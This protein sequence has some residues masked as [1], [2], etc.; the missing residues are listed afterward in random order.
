[1]TKTT[2]AAAQQLASAAGADVAALKQAN[3]AS[4][5]SQKDVLANAMANAALQSGKL[6]E[7]VSS[8]PA[9]AKNAPTAGMKTDIHKHFQSDIG[10]VNL[11]KS[12]ISAEEK[13]RLESELA[14][15]KGSETKVY[16]GVDNETVEITK[17]QIPSS[18]YVVYIK[19]SNNSVFNIK[20]S[21]TKVMVEGC[22]NVTVN[23]HNGTKVLTQVLEAWNC[24]GELTI[25]AETTIKTY[26]IDLSEKVILNVAKRDHFQQVVWATTQHLEVNVAD[27]ETAHKSGLHLVK[28]YNK[29]VDDRIDQFIVRFLK[30]KITLREELREEMLVRLDNGFPTTEREA[31][32]FDRRQEDNLQKLAEQLLGENVKINKKREGPKVGRNDPCTCG[33]AR[34]FKQCCGSNKF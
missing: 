9:P 20:A 31:K 12:G 26:Q 13:K 34:K 11:P 1:M 21:C 33:S 5:E 22:S 24:S 25:N 18:N 7:M 8:A 23:I 17:E 19:K 10:F 27:N 3:S 30:N 14:T 4:I 28:Q 16:H 15:L 6:Q 32:D 2:S 29:V